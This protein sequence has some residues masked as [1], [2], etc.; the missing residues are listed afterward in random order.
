MVSQVQVEQPDVKEDGAGWN[1]NVDHTYT[2][3]SDGCG[4]VLLVAS[5]TGMLLVHSGAHFALYR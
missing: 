4:T 5:M 1:V 2:P 3:R